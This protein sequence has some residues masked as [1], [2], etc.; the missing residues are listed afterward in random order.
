M[1]DLL[2]VLFIDE[3][4]G[5]LKVVIDDEELSRNINQKKKSDVVTN[6]AGEGVSSISKVEYCESDR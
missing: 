2:K 5:N 4:C 6:A 3:K 1:E